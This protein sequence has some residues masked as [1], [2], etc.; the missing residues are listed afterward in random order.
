MPIDQ[1]GDP[2]ARRSS[3]PRMRS[4]SSW[5]PKPRT[6]GVGEPMPAGQPQRGAQG[7]LLG[8]DVYGVGLATYAVQAGERAL[9]V[10][11]R[12]I[13]HAEVHVFLSC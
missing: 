3:S 1:R 5:K 4:V 8:C 9:R 10:N 11:D 2:G 12:E 6:T 13:L 7:V